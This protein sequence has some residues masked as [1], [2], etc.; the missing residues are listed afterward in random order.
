M[1]IKWS[2]AR[3]GENGSLSI[4]GHAG[5]VQIWLFGHARRGDGWGW[6]TWRGDPLAG[7]P[8][9]SEADEGPRGHIGRCSR[10]KAQQAVQEWFD[11]SYPAERKQID[12][13]KKREAK[14]LAAL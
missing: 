5:E 11:E 7:S 14:R 10:F 3:V 9:C 1:T 2:E 6:R 8:L 12:R 4:W 13:D